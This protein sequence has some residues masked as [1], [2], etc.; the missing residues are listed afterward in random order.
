MAGYINS[1]RP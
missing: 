1:Q